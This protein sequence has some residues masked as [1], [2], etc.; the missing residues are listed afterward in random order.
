MSFNAKIIY[1]LL[2]AFYRIRDAEQGKPLEAFLAVIAEQVEV[3]EENLAQ[4]YDDHFIE[5]CAEWVVPYIGDLIEARTQVKPGS[6]VSDRA[7]VANTLKYRRRKGTAAMLEQLARDTTEWPASV[8]EFFQHLAT[9]QSMNH[10]RPGNLS[11]INVRDASA[12]ESLDMPFDTLA[13]NGEVRRIEPRR[14]KY[15]IPNIGI[16]L[17]RLESDSR[18]D[19]EP[20]RVDARRFRFD[21][22]GFDVPLFNDPVTEDEIETLAEPPNVP[23]MLTRTRFRIDKGLYYGR[24]ASVFLTV[25]SNDV[26]ADQIV[27]CDLEDF[28][29]TWG[30]ALDDQYAIDPQLGRIVVPL[31]FPANG[32]LRV[33]FHQGFSDRIGGGEYQRVDSFLGGVESIIDVPAQQPSIQ[34]ALNEVA[35]QF[36]DPILRLSSAAVEITKNRTLSESPALFAPAGKNLELRAGDEQRPVIDAPADITITGGKNAIVSINGIAF[37]GGT[38]Q[39]PQNLSPGLNEL[40]QFSIRHCTLVPTPTRILNGPQTPTIPRLIIEATGVS[41]D[42]DRCIVGSIRAAIGAKVR[43]TNCIVDAGDPTEVAYEG[44]ASGST[45]AALEIENTTII[46]QVHTERLEASNTIFYAER[47]NGGNPPVLAERV[48]EGCVRFSF[49]PLRSKVPRRFHCQPDTSS[50]ADE[51]RV[52][53]VF[54]SRRFGN[55]AYCQLSN[56]CASE[57]TEGADDQS[58]MG[59]FHNLYQPQRV[60]NLRSRLDEY[61]RFG[62]EAG[63]F[64]AT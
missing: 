45:G 38:I 40:E 29:G 7:Q 60:S 17:W 24:D 6:T 16:F 59:V 23:M 15:N 41:V 44:I 9:T 55:P 52:R 10:L 13:H 46:G 48:Q 19:V 18:T 42:I 35:I 64:Y 37:L 28:N 39:V 11:F 36:A 12:L 25:D 8:V 34:S 43:L 2:P 31:S 1:E 51:R 32:I 61:L 27:V 33:L 5:T 21:P 57:I 54:T 26:P 50:T 47:K 22:L 63:I 53:P 14:G 49:V 30:Y 58:E 56:W 62:L 4:R 20:S 3:L